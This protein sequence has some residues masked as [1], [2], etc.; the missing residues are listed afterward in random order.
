MHSFFFPSFPSF[1]AFFPAFFLVQCLP[2][3]TH[4]SIPV[5]A[6]TEELWDS[7]PIRS[8][9]DIAADDFLDA[10]WN[11]DA[12][13]QVLIVCRPIIGSDGLVVGPAT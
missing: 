8:H 3:S 2:P 4:H 7:H 13:E 12:V 1:L 11:L 5:V 9:F 10:I 6:I